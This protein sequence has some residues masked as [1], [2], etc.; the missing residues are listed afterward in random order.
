MAKKPAVDVDA[1]V[2]AALLTVATA[3]T[4]PGLSAK[5]HANPLVPDKKGPNGAVIERLTAAAEPLVVVEGKA[6]A[7]AVRL[8]AAGFLRVL[9]KLSDD[10]VGPLAKAFTA[11]LG[12]ADRVAFLEELVRRTPT[13]APELLPELE[14][15]V[16]AAR[17][18][19]DARVA[20]AAKRREREEA[21][22][23]ALTQWLALLDR[24]QQD[25]LD[26]LRREFE[27]EGGRATD[28]PTPAPR[29]AT[30]EPL[31][32]QTPEEHGFRR[33][34]IRRLAAAWREAV[35]LGREEPARFLEAG[36]GNVRGVR[37]VGDTGETVRFDG[38]AHEADEGVST[39]TPVRVVRPG[40][41]IDEADDRQVVILKAK[42]A[43]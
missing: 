43:R 27:A 35:E 24:R 29:P 10:R 18:E 2:D 5:G 14:A 31:A 1:L 4:P 37:Q 17:A 11:G 16:T 34:V 22:R 41:A 36:I 39:D 32:P 15:A 19:A 38:Q 3:D 13:A 20:A 12:P 21:S 9:P 30:A 7:E 42:V 6:K 8:T 26:A 23:A 25:R 40:W 28:L 33:E